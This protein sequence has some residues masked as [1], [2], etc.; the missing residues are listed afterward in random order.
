MGNVPSSSYT[1]EG[2]EDDLKSLVSYTKLK[3]GS[4]LIQIY[5]HEKVGKSRVLKELFRQIPTDDGC[6][7]KL[8]Y[9]DFERDVK[10]KYRQKLWVKHMCKSFG[11]D[12]QSVEKNNDE[13]VCEFFKDWFIDVVDEKDENVMLFLDNVDSFMKSPLK[14]NFLDFLNISLSDCSRLQ[15]VLTTSIKL[16]L[17][18][19]TVEDHEVRPLED[20]AVMCLL[21]EV[22]KHHYKDGELEIRERHNVYLQWVAN[23]CE[24]RPQLA[25]T[26]G[27][28]LVED[29]YFLKPRELLELMISCR[30]QC[31]SPFN[32]PP[33]ER[34][35]NLSENIRQLDEEIQTCFKRL[36][37]SGPDANIAEEST[38]SLLNRGNDSLAR[39][40]L[41]V[42]K[43]ILDH[44]LLDRDPKNRTFELHGVVR[45]NV[46]APTDSDSEEG[47][48]IARTNAQKLGMTLTEAQLRD[49]RLLEATLKG[50]LNDTTLKETKVSFPADLNKKDDGVIGGERDDCSTI[51]AR[52]V[53]EHE[54]KPEQRYA[55]NGLGKLALVETTCTRATEEREEVVS[56]TPEDSLVTYE[57]T[58]SHDMKTLE[59]SKYDSRRTI[60]VDDKVVPFSLTSCSNQP[61]TEPNA[62]CVEQPPSY[63]TID[64][65]RPGNASTRVGLGEQHAGV[66][67]G[68]GL[69][70]PP[71][72]RNARAPPLSQASQV[73]TPENVAVVRPEITSID[74]QI[75]PCALS[76]VKDVP[77]NSLSKLDAGFKNVIVTICDVF[78]W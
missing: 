54:E 55:D 59:G 76:P 9:Q 34:M 72:E 2:R 43:D 36:S 17:T 46:L 21:H 44:K 68:Q 75:G 15:I 29:E 3:A 24:G 64:P 71:Y 37:R 67:V 62:V 4:R 40:K 58:K 33:G 50:S 20:D 51:N 49:P 31:L 45:E 13:P 65:I 1:L 56:T 16:K 12:F 74:S 48:L 47:V 19:L 11:K 70:P 78:F 52:E 6:K 14:D 42:I 63:H 69:S 41:F 28:L 77:S 27:V 73:P 7:R 23:L 32:C 39:V 26:A 60:S 66:F 38:Y 18:Q 57:H 35:E 61:E 5:G 8:L 10:S 30:R 25:I 22:T 53:E